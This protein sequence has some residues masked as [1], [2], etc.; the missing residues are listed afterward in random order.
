MTEARESIILAIKSGEMSD[1]AAILIEEI[2]VS[3]MCEIV[4]EQ[5]EVKVKQENMRSIIREEMLN[6]NNRI[7]LLD[8]RLN[9]KKTADLGKMGEE[10]V[11]EVV[12]RRYNVEN[13]SKTGGRG[14]MILDGRILLEVKNYSSV[15]PTKEV[16]K[17]ISDVSSTSL[18][19]GLMLSLNT[20]ITGKG[21]FKIE[22]QSRGKGE[23]PLLY[24]R[25]SDERVI[26]S[27]LEMLNALI[28]WSERR[29]LTADDNIYETLS[30]LER[31]MKE[32][33]DSMSPLIEMINR[34]RRESNMNYEKLLSEVESRR[35]EI[36][37]S[38]K[39]CMIPQ[40][41]VLI[42]KDADEPNTILEDNVVDG[43]VAVAKKKR[44][45]KRKI[46]D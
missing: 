6:I 32:L 23:V 22:W 3:K 30:M 38:Y 37:S 27:S 20:D 16:T 24:V 28:E 8:A 5:L 11:Y 34:Q 2:G 4:L 19:G 9:T 25:S 33:S 26:L 46:K 21:G 1:R 7:E 39:L 15:V 29:L 42:Y 43:S 36:L 40:K 17:Y 13:V 31:R 45:Y 10:Y 12:S 35:V 14:D 18:S 41:N 44:V